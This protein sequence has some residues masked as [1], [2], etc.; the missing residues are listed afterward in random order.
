MLT[1]V[2]V[3]LL[4]GLAQSEQDGFSL[5]QGI[6]KRLI[7]QHGLDAGSEYRGVHRFYEEFVCAG[8][9]AGDFVLNPLDTRQ[10]E[11]GNEP[12]GPV[13]FQPTAKIGPA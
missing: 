13:R 12:G 9:N 1:G 11:H 3:P 2:L 10:H 6:D 7:P 8:G 4:Y 5:F